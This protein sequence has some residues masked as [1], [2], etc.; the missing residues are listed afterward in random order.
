M[1]SMLEREL[2]GLLSQ[3]EGPRGVGAYDLPAAEEGLGVVAMGTHIA[4]TSGRRPHRVVEQKSFRTTGAEDA[5][6][7]VPRASPPIALR[8]LGVVSRVGSG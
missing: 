4:D 7:G 1:G 8:R 3:G 2:S 6:H 5:D